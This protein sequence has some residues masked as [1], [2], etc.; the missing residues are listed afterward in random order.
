MQ[1]RRLGRTGHESSVAILGGAAFW[2]STVEVV[3]EAFERAVAAGVNHLDIAPQYGMAEDLSGQVLPR[4]REGMF[5]GCKTLQRD[6]DGARAE[7]E[8]S[9]GK[10]RTDHFDLYQMHAVTTD[11]DL[12]AVL[13]PGGAG[14]ALRRARDEGLVR[15]IGI[16]GHFQEVPRLFHT[17]VERL[18]LDTVMLPVNPPMLA[19][20][21]YRRHFDALLELA[22]ARDLGVMAIKAVARGPWRTEEHTATTWYEP[23]RELDAIRDG[24]RFALSFPIT[25][26]AMPGDVS[27]HAAALAAAEEF[28]PLEPRE[29]GDRI[30]AADL[31]D[32]LVSA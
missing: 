1:R 6:A 21:D 20:P 29:I 15:A 13:A 4:Y 31:A 5:V 8:R 11:E 30:A 2:D 26:F 14:E 25:G 24:V 16:T 9:L 18:D 7:L 23:H 12:A 10:L 17:A 28:T 22:A 3:A 19:L 27:L 32:A